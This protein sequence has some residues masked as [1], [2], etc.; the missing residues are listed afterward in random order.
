MNNIDAILF[1]PV[2]SLAEFPAEPFV[3]I[4]KR[5]FQR[6]L[7]P[8]VSGSQAYWDVLNLLAAVVQ[9]LDAQD[10]AVIDEC[11]QRAVDCAS[12]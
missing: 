12:V 8:G 4:A 7:A 9:P 11:E 1:D 3:D 10:C 6:V 2:G 5:V